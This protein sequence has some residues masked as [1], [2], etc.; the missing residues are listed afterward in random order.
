MQ[1]PT[2][3]HW[4][5]G[6]LVSWGCP[7]K[8]P[9]MVSSNNTSLFVH[10]SGGRKSCSE[11]VGRVML[12]LMA[13]GEILLV[14]CRFGGCRCSMTCGSSFH[15][16][17]LASVVFFSVFSLFL[18]LIRTF[19]IRFRVHLDKPWRSQLKILNLIISVKTTFQS[20]GPF[21]FQSLGHRHVF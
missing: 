19:V 11:G 3:L 10:S 7:N 4:L 9:P 20:K 12:P 8:L 2:G 13:S 6:G 18:F 14:S 15:S 17:P 1:T 21:S 5:P 16:P